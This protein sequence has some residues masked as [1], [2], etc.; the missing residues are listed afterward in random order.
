MQFG[1]S[2]PVSYPMKNYALNVSTVLEMMNGEKYLG[3][4]CTSDLKPSLL[5]QKAVAKAL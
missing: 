1:Y 2:P 4:W 3:I 5:C